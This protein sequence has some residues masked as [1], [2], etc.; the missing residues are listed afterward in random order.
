MREPNLYFDINIIFYN[1]HMGLTCNT[2]IFGLSC[3]ISNTAVFS[4]ALHS[5]LQH[6]QNIEVWVCLFFWY[7]NASCIN[8]TPPRFPFSSRAMLRYG[9]GYNAIWQ[10]GLIHSVS[11]RLSRPTNIYNTMLRTWA[12]KLSNDV[13]IFCLSHSK[14]ARRVY[15]HK[16]R[17]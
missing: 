17:P 14:R 6:L 12:D 4:G 7:R 11:A 15:R 10:P 9:G 3:S 16:W 2:T 1:L 13:Y 8:T 5:F